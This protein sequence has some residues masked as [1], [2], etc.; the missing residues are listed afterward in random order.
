FYRIMSILGDR[1][2]NTQTLLTLAMEIGQLNYQIMQLLDQ[3][4]TQTFGHPCPTNVNLKPKQGQ[5]IL[6]SG[7]DFHDLY[8]L[9]RQ[10]ENSGINVYTHGEMLPAHA[11]PVFQQFSH[12]VGHYG[13]AW[14]NQQLEFANFP[15]PIVMTSNCLIDPFKGQYNQR[16]F[17]RSMVGWPGVKHL[18]GND[19]S[20]V[21]NCA[22]QQTGFLYTE[23]EQSIT[24]GFAR[25]TLINSVDTLIEQIKLG[26]I[27]H[28]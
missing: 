26:N 27:K 10:T 4:A 15:G 13:S 18:E 2:Q 22:K 23:L 25:Q 8:H 20:E 9:L 16:I 12:L 3:G 28:A 17:T 7:H 5:A 6:I 1:P 14:Q 19:F 11:Y 24:V 21:I